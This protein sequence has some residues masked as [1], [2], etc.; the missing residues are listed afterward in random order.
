MPRNGVGNY[1][2]P[3]PPF[4][5]GAVISNASVNS[6]LSD[7]AAALTQSVSADGQTLITGQLKFPNGT[8]AA[9][10]ISFSSDLSTGMYWISAKHLGFSTGGTEIVGFNANNQGSGQTGNVIEINTPT[11]TI[12]PCPVGCVL[13]FAGTTAPG[14]W[15]LCYGQVV[16]VS[17]YPELFV[18]L[19]STNTYGGN[20]TTTFGIPDCQ[21]RATYGRDNMSGVDQG[22][23]TVA[24]LNFDGTILGNAG[25]SQFHL[26]SA[27]E[28]PLH[29]HSG[30][31]SG[32]SVSHSHTQGGTFTLNQQFIQPGGAIA[33]AGGAAAFSFQNGS[34][35]ISGNTSIQSADHTHSF[36]TDNGTV[37]GQYHT[38][39]SPAIIFNKI[40][41]AGRV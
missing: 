35:T 8:A 17:S 13:D 27:N 7:I 26:L 10:S 16:N 41:F 23:I 21:G 18:A 37:N 22:R 12:Y 19:G 34:V 1:S 3:Q 11:G 6:D 25:G 38:I 33:I 15:L 30:T 31:T 32:E 9:P 4:T 14:G 5:P 20:G 2:L 39:L 24:G 29:T 28:T 40:I 36:T